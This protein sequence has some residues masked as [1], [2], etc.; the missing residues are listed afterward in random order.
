MS[1]L[2]SE[3]FS[4]KKKTSDRFSFRKC[5][6]KNPSRECWETLLIRMYVLWGLHQQG[7]GLK[8]SG[9]CPLV[10]FCVIFV[11]FVHETIWKYFSWL[12]QQPSYIWSP[13]GVLSYAAQQ[14]NLCRMQSCSTARSFKLHLNFNPLL[15]GR[16]LHT[17]R[18]L[19]LVSR[20]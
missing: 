14:H 8:V 7:Y 13:F 2:Y 19:V 16:N 15:K 9:C 3:I 1:L 17:Y 6:R 18:H 5:S 12:F 4:Q 10:F 11:N 20:F